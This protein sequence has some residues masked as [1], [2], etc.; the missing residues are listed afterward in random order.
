MTSDCDARVLGKFFTLQ[1]LLHAA[2]DDKWLGSALCRAVV[3]LPGVCSA[4]LYLHDEHVAQSSSVTF[5]VEWPVECPEDT[6]QLY[7]SDSSS[8]RRFSLRTTKQ[9]HG[10]FFIAVIGADKLVPYVVH[11]ENTLS[12]VALLLENR[13][14]NKALENLAA[15]LEE[16]V[17]A[18][19]EEIAN[20]EARFQKMFREHNAVMLLL[21][22]ETGSIIDANISACD[23][24]GYPRG[25]LIS[26]S[27]D[28]INIMSSEEV[29]AVMAEAREKKN[30]YFESKHRLASGEIREVES[31]SYPIPIDGRP[32]LFAIIHDITERK[33]SC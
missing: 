17:N 27:M 33:K 23:Y 3:E 14:Q 31:Y 32:L 30:N 16:K 9:K 20:H 18:Q 4:A 5:P 11:L 25:T 28:Q 21:D 2:H 15:E 22:P 24:Y 13:H 29:Q 26:M 1:T 6:S 19:V 8:V 10:Q 12:L 7:F